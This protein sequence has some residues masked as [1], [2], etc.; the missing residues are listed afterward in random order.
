M[1]Q[2][3]LTERASVL[4]QLVVLTS[5]LYEKEN[6]SEGQKGLLETIIGAG[7]WYLPSGV[8][9]YSGYISKSALESL[10]K[11]PMNTK[12]VEEHSYPRKLAAASLLK[13]EVIEEVR[14]N[15][16]HLRELYTRSFGCFNLVLKSE[17]DRLKKYQ[18]KGV[19]QS[20]E[21]S[22]REAGIEL[23][24]FSPEK[25]QE[26]KRYKS[27]RKKSEMFFLVN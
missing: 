10:R 24:P 12:L 6:L 27:G 22:Y 16:G 1:N 23:V 5:S 25:Y 4:A 13:K 8:E 11:D 2:K 14:K 18:K 7:I 9:L 20:E 26:F 17:N 19:F 15:E 21:Q 3:N